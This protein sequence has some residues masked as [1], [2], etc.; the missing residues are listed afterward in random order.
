MASYI[1]KTTCPK[2]LAVFSA[3]HDEILRHKYECPTCSP[4]VPDPHP[5]TVLLDFIQA[6]PNPRLRHVME[7]WK[8]CEGGLTLRGSIRFVIEAKLSL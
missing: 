2:C 8:R 4:R 5:D 1:S 7:A 6:A 3:I